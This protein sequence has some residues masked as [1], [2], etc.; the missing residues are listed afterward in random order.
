MVGAVPR[1]YWMML[2]PSRT[3]AET[4]AQA[5]WA[6]EHG[7]EGVFSIELGT[8]P[9]VPLGAAAAGT[10]QLQLATGIALG[11]ARPPFDIAVAALDLDRLS[12]GRF[13]LGLGTSVR[14]LNVNHFGVAYDRPV[15]RMAE[16][17]R[18]IKLVTSGRARAE[19]RIDGEFSH[20]DFS[21]LE[22]PRPARP[23]IPLWLAALRTPLVR[24]AGEQADGLMGH[25]S[26]SVSWALQQVNGPFADAVRR[27]GRTRADVAVNLWQVVAPHPDPRQAVADAKKHVARY[28]GIAQ[29]E[30]FFAAHGYQAEARQL[31]AAARDG[32][33]GTA[34]VP[35][36]MARTFVVCGTPDQ[37]RA[38]L[39]PLWA[40]ADSICLQP[41]PSTRE[42]R[43]HYEELIAATFYG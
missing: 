36:E 1:R 19:G 3:A 23:D 9:W 41:P 18:I 20:L 22:M 21:A 6:E 24:L 26:W 40:V 17:I 16:A 13:T 34:F 29:Y 32:V 28:A 11:L 7:L 25:P 10:T 38:Q 4:V 15:E 14:H 8:N 33:D 12:E 27:S 30:A 35:D 39:E 31:Q 5:K 2:R 37:V 43:M 42:Q